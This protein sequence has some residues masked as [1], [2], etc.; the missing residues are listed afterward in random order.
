[1]RM[2]V[3]GGADLHTY[4]FA[5]ILLMVVNWGLEAWKWR[6]LVRDIER[7]TMARAF[8]ATIAG[9]SIGMITPNRVG[10]FAGRVLFLVP[11]NRITGAFATAVGSIAQFAVTLVMGCAGLVA[12]LLA[13][14]GAEVGPQAVAWITLCSIVAVCTLLLYFNPGLLRA[15]VARVPVVRRWAQQSDVLAQFT[16]AK[17][18]VVLLLSAARYVVFTAQFVLLIRAVADVGLVDAV[19]TVPIAFLFSTLVPTLML[20]ELGVRGSIA[21]AV[22]S[23]EGDTGQGVFLAS[24]LLWLVNIAAPA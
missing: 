12:V 17:L 8:T 4:G 15:V 10:E 7:L 23:S 16:Q 13:S 11:E 5:V 19:L 9:T 6:L 14:D 18:L 2:V 1:M 21:V 22:I 20:T 3:R 24:T